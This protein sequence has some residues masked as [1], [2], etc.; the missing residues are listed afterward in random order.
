MIFTSIYINKNKIYSNNNDIYINTQYTV[1][2]LQ[3]CFRS[4]G[5]LK[6][7]VPDHWW[8]VEEGLDQV[9]KEELVV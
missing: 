7:C 3:R 5:K 2:T 9:V 8:R 4:C 1:Y 6:Q